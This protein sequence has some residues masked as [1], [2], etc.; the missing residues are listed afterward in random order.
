MLD[1][2]GQ[3]LILCMGSLVGVRKEINFEIGGKGHSERDMYRGEEISQTIITVEKQE[4][5]Y[6]Q[7]SCK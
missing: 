1:D 6:G 2:K 4:S 3:V 5:E 7:G